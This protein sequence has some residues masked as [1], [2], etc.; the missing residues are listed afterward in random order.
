MEKLEYEGGE[1]GI[2][3]HGEYSSS[4]GRV[5]HPESGKSVPQQKGR[6]LQEKKVLYLFSMSGIF[7]K[8][9]RYERKKCNPAAMRHKPGDTQ[10]NGRRYYKQSRF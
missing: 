8:E 4:Y 3:R 7:Q 5:G 1:Q 2:C 10:K 6:V 9:Q